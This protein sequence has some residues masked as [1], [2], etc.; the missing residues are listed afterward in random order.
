LRIPKERFEQSIYE[1]VSH[2]TTKARYVEKITGYVIAEWHK[3]ENQNTNNIKSMQS[4]ITRMEENIRTFVSNMKY[5][6][7]AI[8]I[9][10][11]EDEISNTESEIRKAKEIVAYYQDKIVPSDAEIEHRIQQLLSNIG[12]LISSGD[13]DYTIRALHFAFLFKKIPSYYE[14]A[15]CDPINLCDIFQYSKPKSIC[16]AR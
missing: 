3:R 2:I 6:K 9:E 14:V 13:C 4:E 16:P 15:E 12:D 1:F 11:A 8:S 10:Y 7:S 5:M